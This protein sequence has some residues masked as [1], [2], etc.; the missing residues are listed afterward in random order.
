KNIF[1]KDFIERFSM[2]DSLQNP[3]IPYGLKKHHSVFKITLEELMRQDE[4]IYVS[5]IP[6][7]NYID[8]IDKEDYY[9]NMKNLWQ[10]IDFHPRIKNI[11]NKSKK[12]AK[13]LVDGFIAIHIRIADVALNEL[14]KN[15]GFF[16]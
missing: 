12:I 3:G 16:V 11:I 1:S 7:Y 10:Q 13:Q 8:D 15:T 4:D 6:C 9:E 5:H 2:G 14:Y